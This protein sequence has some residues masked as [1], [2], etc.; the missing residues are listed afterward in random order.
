[1]PQ[2]RYPPFAYRVSGIH[3]S[4]LIVSVRI[5]ENKGFNVVFE[6]DS[7]ANSARQLLR[8]LNAPGEIKMRASFSKSCV[9]GRMPS[10]YLTVGQGSP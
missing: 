9:A 2:Q 3:R 8:A 10:P 6:D 7:E 4:R 5:S 1:M